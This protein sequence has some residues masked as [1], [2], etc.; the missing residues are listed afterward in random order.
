MVFVVGGLTTNILPM[1]EA[2]LPTFT[3]SASSNHESILSTKCLN[4]AEPRIFCSPKITRYTVVLA[5]P[6][7]T[8]QVSTR[9][10]KIKLRNFRPTNEHARSFIRIHKNRSQKYEEENSHLHSYMYMQL[11]TNQN[12]SSSQCHCSTCSVVSFLLNDFSA[13]NQLDTVLQPDD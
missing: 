6:I 1:N 7:S 3:C 4:I 10:H 8:T 9:N 12:V 2:T 13:L 5:Y 11:S